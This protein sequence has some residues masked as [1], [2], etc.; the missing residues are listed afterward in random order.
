MAKFK[1]GFIGLGLMGAPM[2]KNILKKGF[3]LVVFNR[4]LSKTTEFKKLGAQV[5]NSSAELANQVDVVITMVTAGQDVEKVLFGKK[6]VA[7]GA[8]KRFDC[9]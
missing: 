8:K 1:V 5:A 4:T 3:H 6:G 9:H 2:A 7:A